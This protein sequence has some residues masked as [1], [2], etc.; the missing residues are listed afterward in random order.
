MNNWWI[1]FWWIFWCSGPKGERGYPGETGLPGPPGPPGTPG[2]SSLPVQ[3]RGDVFQVDNQ[4]EQST[5]LS[6]RS[7]LELDYNRSRFW[8]HMGEFWIKYSC[9]TI[10][11]FSFWTVW[12]DAKTMGPLSQF[13]LQWVI[14]FTSFKHSHISCICS[15]AIISS[16]RTWAL[17]KWVRM[18]GKQFKRGHRWGESTET[19]TASV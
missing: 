15:L 2:L 16:G 19:K 17:A 3:M 14:R 8:T 10:R 11:A 12:N 5:P 18:Y 1:N 6:F 4:G 9:E 7:G 13:I